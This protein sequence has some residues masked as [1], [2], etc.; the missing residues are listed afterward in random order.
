LILGDSAHLKSGYANII[1]EIGRGLVKE[2]HE[3]AQIG[4]YQSEAAND[5]EIG[6]PIYPI[7]SDDPYGIKNFDSIV[8]KFKPDIVF[9]VQDPYALVWLPNMMTRNRFKFCFYVPI[10]SGPIPSFWFPLLRNADKLIGFCNFA[11]EEVKKSLH[12]EISVVYPGYDSNIF[13]EM[14][15]G[16]D[17][18]KERNGFKDDFVFGYVGVNAVRKQ[19]YRLIEAFSKVKKKHPNTKLFMHT[20]V[21]NE[22]EG[23]NLNEAAVQTG[24]KPNDVLFSSSAGPFGIEI[25]KMNLIYN[26]FDV[27]CLPSNSE[28]FGLPILEAAAC[29]VP[30]IATNYSSMPELIEGHGELVKPRDWIMH[31]P[32]CQKRALIDIDSLASRM[33]KMVENKQLLNQ[34]SKKVKEWA[35]KY[36]WDKQIGK[37]IQEIITTERNLE[38][39]KIE[40][41]SLLKI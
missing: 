9:G 11:R 13:F 26:L 22:K 32:Y 12:I 38:E 4:W 34:Y 1:R 18:I 41:F 20:Q 7:N 30:T 28:G 17:T 10:D 5:E 27:L 25:E 19:P 16:K 33:C 15:D 2:G 39:R 29:G 8:Y 37:F 36:T 14:N 31:N 35:S 24:L 40:K 6:F 21:V 3:V 23:W